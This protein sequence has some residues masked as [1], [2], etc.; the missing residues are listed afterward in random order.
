MTRGDG[1]ADCREGQAGFTLLELLIAMTLLGLLMTLIFSGLRFGTRVWERNEVHGAG[2]DEVRLVQSLIRGEIEAAY[3]YYDVT[4]ASHPHVVFD[5]RP[6]SVSFLAPTP[7]ALGAAGR[8]R[9]SFIAISQGS[10][11]KLVMTAR[12]E[13]ARDEDDKVTERDVLLDGLQAVSF[14]YFGSDGPGDAPHWRDRWE[15]A[16]RVPLLVRVALKFEKS[17]NRLWPEMIVAPRI[18]VDV[19]CSYDPLT[20]YCQGR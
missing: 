5:G 15:D 17:G 16:T 2:T 9:V 4:D 18:S 7:F 3:P 6:D 14:S 20:K 19:A 11:R 1:D 12:P 10:S 8:S 13:L